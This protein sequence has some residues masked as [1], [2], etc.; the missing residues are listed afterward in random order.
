MEKEQWR[1]MLKIIPKISI[2]ESLV[3]SP[4]L[5]YSQSI[6]KP[7]SLDDIGIRDYPICNRF[8]IEPSD[9]IHMI[10]RF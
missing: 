8:E 9:P 7:T 1:N 3:T 10:W 6:Q 5:S 2:S 4:P